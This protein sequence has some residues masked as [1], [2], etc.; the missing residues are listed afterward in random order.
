VYDGKKTYADFNSTG[1]VQ[2]RYL[3][4]PGD[5]QILARTSSGGA[6]GWYLAD[7]L[8]S[9]RDVV[10]SSATVLFHTGYD[11]FGNQVNQ[12]GTGGDRFL[13]TAQQYD[14]FV[15]LYYSAVPYYSPAVGRLV[16]R[17]PD[18]FAAGD[19]NLYRYGGNAPTSTAA[20]SSAY[21]SF[22]SDYW[23][24]LTHP[25]DQDTDIQIGQGIA[26]GTAGVCIVAA[27]GLAIVG[28]NPVLWG[29]GATVVAAGETASLGVGTTAVVGPGLGAGTY[30]AL[31][32]DGVVYVHRF[33]VLAA[34]LAGGA[35]A[36]GTVQKYGMAIIDAGGT[37]IG[38]L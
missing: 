3:Y 26:L 4:E 22:W 2:E 28:F 20:S 13:F 21:K 17:N 16:S 23:H 27:G 12:S 33:H 1:A 18:G 10:N 6:T 35:A 25:G 29:G 34:E 38:W 14:S 30:P 7:R 19:P 31:L 32:I 5:D 9:V 11:S 37:V 36:C 24:Y 15:A 8:G